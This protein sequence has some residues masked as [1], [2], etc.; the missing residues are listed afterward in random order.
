MI[1]II[2]MFSKDGTATKKK[3]GKHSR[4]DLV[5]LTTKLVWNDLDEISHKMVP[6]SFIEFIREHACFLFFCLCQAF[7]FFFLCCLFCVVFT[8]AAYY[9]RHLSLLELDYR[10]DDGNDIDAL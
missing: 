9:L 3:K 6:Q 1:F 7:F 8:K 4:R 5:H 10:D 2:M